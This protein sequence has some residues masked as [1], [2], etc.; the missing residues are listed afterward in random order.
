[1]IEKVK[2]YL[3]W[4]LLILV[5]AIVVSGVGYISGFAQLFFT[6]IGGFSAYILPIVVILYVVVWVIG[7]FRE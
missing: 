2:N 1:M 5:L 4:L 7:K 6:R 3:K